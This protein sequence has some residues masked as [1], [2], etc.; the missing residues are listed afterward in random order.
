M[1]GTSLRTQTG[2]RILHELWVSL[3][4]DSPHSLSIPTAAGA[5]G[6]EIAAE[7]RAKRLGVECGLG[8]SEP[9]LGSL[10]LRGPEAGGVSGGRC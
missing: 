4:M 3:A 5:E 1:E 6:R 8:D 2:W 9:L 10:V 7:Q